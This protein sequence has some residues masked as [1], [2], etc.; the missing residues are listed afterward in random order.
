MQTDQGKSSPQNNPSFMQRLQLREVAPDWAASIGLIFAGAYIVLVIAGQV[1]VATL[2]GSPYIAPSPD[3]IAVGTLL[4]SIVTI[5]G[6]V[7][8]ARRRLGETW[9]ESLRLRPPLKPSLTLIAL[10]ALGAAWATDLV[11]LAL[12]LRV[13]QTVPLVLARLNGA[14]NLAWIATAVLA[15]V[16]QPIVEGL[17]FAG[18]LYPALARDRKNNLLAAT[19]CA[20]AYVLASLIVLAAGSGVWYSLIQ[21]F[22]MALVM[23][24]V[25]AYT[26]STQSAIIARAMFGLFFVNEIRKHPR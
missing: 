7:Q 6:I 14:V 11:G 1:V 5:I 9:T 26:Q 8:W 13:D 12:R 22:I 21:P 17:I 20:L 3:A 24:L 18:V 23:L 10:I 16:V 25:R 19:L 2:S 15:I 4:G